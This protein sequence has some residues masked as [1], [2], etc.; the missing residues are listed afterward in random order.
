MHKSS[1]YDY[2]ESFYKMYKSSRYDYAESFYYDCAKSYDYA[3][4]INI[5]SKFLIK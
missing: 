4:N 5:L 3:N 1:R 2:A